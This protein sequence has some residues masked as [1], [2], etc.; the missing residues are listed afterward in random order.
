MASKGVFGS[1]CGLSEL[2]QAES[3]YVHHIQVCFIVLC[4]VGCM[5]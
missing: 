2:I 1:L 4:L 3:S 5:T